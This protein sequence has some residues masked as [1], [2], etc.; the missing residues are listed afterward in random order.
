[1][2]GCCNL[3]ARRASAADF[4]TG[5]FQACQKNINV[6]A[7]FSR[8]AFTFGGQATG[9]EAEMAGLT[10]WAHAAERGRCPGGPCCCC[11]RA[12]LL[13]RRCR[14]RG[15]FSRSRALGRLAGRA[16]PQGAAV[17]VARCTALCI[18]R[19]GRR[20]RTAFERNPSTKT[21]VPRSFAAAAARVSSVLSA[22][23]ACCVLSDRV[24]SSS[25][26][27]ELSFARAS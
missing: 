5:F 3:A 21:G 27:I 22:L 16:S 25:L 18:L 13:T 15:R 11:W 7:S 12:A 8:R 9:L 17:A 10:C 23:P 14:R 26:K 24:N 2:R 6:K 4:K 19:R 1:M 20:R